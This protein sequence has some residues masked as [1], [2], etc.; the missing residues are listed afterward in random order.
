MKSE[1]FASAVAFFN[2]FYIFGLLLI[3]LFSLDDLLVTLSAQR[4]VFLCLAK[5]DAAV[6]GNGSVTDVGQVSALDADGV[7]LG[8]VVSNGAEG[9]HGTEGNAAEIHVETGDDDADAA[10]CQFVTYFGESGIEKLCLIDAY[11]VDVA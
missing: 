3:C 9:W 6:V 5:Q 4:L 11:N 1:E 8:D 2:I 10:I 7:N